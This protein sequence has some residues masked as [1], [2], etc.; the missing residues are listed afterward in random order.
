MKWILAALLA[1]LLS[2]CHDNTSELIC[3]HNGGIK[4]YHVGSELQV[5]CQDGTVHNIEWL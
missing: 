2:G 3:Q 1:G 4:K 5:T